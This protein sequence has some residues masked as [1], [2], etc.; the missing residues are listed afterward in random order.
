MKN[1]GKKWSVKIKT[2]SQKLVPSEQAKS[3]LLPEELPKEIA[4]VLKAS[5]FRLT[6][7]QSLFDYYPDYQEEIW[8]QQSEDVGQLLIILKISRDVDLFRGSLRPWAE[9]FAQDALS[10][11]CC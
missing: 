11:F 3:S 6:R 5:S 8:V 9:H 10:A 4:S 7:E 1:K 2:S